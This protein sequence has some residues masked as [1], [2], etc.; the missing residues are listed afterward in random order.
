MSETTDKKM[1]LLRSARTYVMVARCMMRDG[2]AATAKIYLTHAKEQVEL[3]RRLEDDD[4]T[5]TISMIID[6]MDRRAA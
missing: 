3:A 2:D 5:K 6:E 1:V 4:A